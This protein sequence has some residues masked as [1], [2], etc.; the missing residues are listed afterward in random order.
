[1][2]ADLNCHHN[3]MMMKWT[4]QT[5]TVSKL[6]SHLWSLKM[7]WRKCL[8]M[9]GKREYSWFSFNRAAPSRRSRS[10]RLCLVWK[11]ESWEGVKT[12]QDHIIQDICVTENTQVRRCSGCLC[13]LFH[14]LLQSLL[15]FYNIS[16]GDVWAGHIPVIH[17]WHL[18]PGLWLAVQWRVAICTDQ[19]RC[20]LCPVLWPSFG[21]L[22]LT[23]VYWTYTFKGRHSMVVKQN[24]SMLGKCCSQ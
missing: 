4:N 15:L 20:W 11:R 3:M 18:I 1:M 12:N 9:V 7:S 17:E 21:H 6:F 10:A 5:T 8:S 16:K 22:W 19:E 23:P 24:D 14:I 13:Y 2:E